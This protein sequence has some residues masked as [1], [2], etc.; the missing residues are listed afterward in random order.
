[1]IKSFLR[2]DV[3]FPLLSCKETK[4]E[5]DKRLSGLRNLLYNLSFCGDPK[6]FEWLWNNIKQTFL[7]DKKE[8]IELFE[9]EFIQ[10]PNVSHF[11]LDP[12]GSLLC[13]LS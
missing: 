2:D 11:L 6:L 1:M 10:G 12:S 5:R 8:F 4:D 9:S 7:R 3:F 13:N